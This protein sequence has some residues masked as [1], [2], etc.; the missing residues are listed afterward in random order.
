V[1]DFL[2]LVSCSF[3]I[4][5]Y[6]PLSQFQII[7]VHLHVHTVP[8]KRNGGPKGYKAVKGK[9][10]GKGGKLRHGYGYGK[11][12]GKGK[13][14][15]GYGY[16]KVKGG[17]GKGKGKGGYGYGYG[18]VKG[19]YGKGKGKN[20]KGY[21]YGYGGEIGGETKVVVE[22]IIY[23][24]SGSGSK[25]CKYGDPKYPCAFSGPQDDDIDHNGP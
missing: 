20:K 4:F 18:K 12:K 9:G 16:G 3:L 6:H 15:Y 17:Y 24:G 22:E 5:F 14:G 11:G 10:K 7:H 23:Y 21:G 13:G 8:P 19:G 1:N 2:Y 25:P